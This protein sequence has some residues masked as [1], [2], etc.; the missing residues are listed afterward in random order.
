MPDD[1]KTITAAAKEVIQ[2]L[3]AQWRGEAD[4]PLLFLLTA[5][6]A[7]T[8]AKLEARIHDLEKRLGERCSACKG[9]DPS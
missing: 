1:E 6:T 7:V 4:A 9:C 3:F 8:I 5:F 2:T